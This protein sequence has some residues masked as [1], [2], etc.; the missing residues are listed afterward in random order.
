MQNKLMENMLD[1]GEEQHTRRQRR[2]I[3]KRADSSS[4]SEQQSELSDMEKEADSGQRVLRLKEERKQQRTKRR[5]RKQNS[6]G[7][8]AG[9]SG[10][11]QK[12]AEALTTVPLASYPYLLPPVFR[13]KKRRKRDQAQQ[14][15]LQLLPVRVEEHPPL[16]DDLIDSSSEDEGEEVQ[17]LDRPAG[18]EREALEGGMDEFDSVCQTPTRYG[19]S[20]LSVSARR[21]TGP[22]RSVNFKLTDEQLI[23]QP[24]SPVFDLSEPTDQ[25]SLTPQLPSTNTACT[26]QHA[27]QQHPTTSFRATKPR[28]CSATD[29]KQ[30]SH[31]VAEPT[32]TATQR[33]EQQQSEEDDIERSDEERD[34]VKREEEVN[35]AN[36]INRAA[37]K[38]HSAT[39]R[40]SN[41]NTGSTER[42][43]LRTIVARARAMRPDVPMPL[44]S[45]FRLPLV[46][47]LTCAASSPI[48][49][50]LTPDPANSPK[51]LVKKMSGIVQE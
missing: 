43:R 13:R 41:S 37:T 51:G 50:L 11:V 2:K 8:T 27:T 5:A 32:R 6:S 3:S 35:D 42:A 40:S 12:S 21:Y 23:S 33:E 16:E 28:Q 29:K 10:R 48:L 9:V 30:P 25:P 17:Q 49:R 18:S 4:S 31:H 15:K 47:A 44:S 45:L 22:K 39:P 7:E 20:T 46:A 34:Q 19:R 36:V 14:V 1:E 26:D 38:V 24:L